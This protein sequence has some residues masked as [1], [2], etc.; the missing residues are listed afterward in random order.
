MKNT[1]GSL[2]YELVYDGKERIEQDLKV[3]EFS[4][5]FA[6]LQKLF[7]WLLSY[8]KCEMISSGMLLWALRNK[9]RKVLLEFGLLKTSKGFPDSRETYKTR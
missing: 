4:F 7:V 1:F 9:N 5:L 3:V 2:N 6:Y 8:S